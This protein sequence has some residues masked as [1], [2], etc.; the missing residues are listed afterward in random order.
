MT[1]KELIRTIAE[2]ENMT[3][4]KTTAIVNAVFDTIK[5]RIAEGEEVSITKFGK[6]KAV[7]R[8]GTIPGTSNKYST[9]IPKFKASSSFKE[10]LK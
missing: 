10:D 1:R 3:Y 9:T 4:I 7:S 8:V 2:E 5:S 6:F